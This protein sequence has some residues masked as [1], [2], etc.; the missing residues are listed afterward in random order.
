[1][2]EREILDVVYRQIVLAYEQNLTDTAPQHFKDLKE[3][4]EDQRSKKGEDGGGWL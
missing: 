3:Y 2:K 1:M 4:I